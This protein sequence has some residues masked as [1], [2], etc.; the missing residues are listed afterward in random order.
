MHRL[1]TISQ[2]SIRPV[3]RKSST[4]YLKH[5]LIRSTS[6]L[7]P[8]GPSGAILA[9]KSNIFSSYDRKA[10]TAFINRNCDF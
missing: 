5:Y 1:V 6:R 9:V 4:I 2:Q 3:I 8:R 10:G 7:T